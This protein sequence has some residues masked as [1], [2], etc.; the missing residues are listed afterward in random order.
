MEV[1]IFEHIIDKKK[2]KNSKTLAVLNQV[3]VPRKTPSPDM[4]CET[5]SPAKDSLNEPNTGKL[6]KKALGFD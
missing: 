6:N 3:V 4:L 1:V 5:V 2:N